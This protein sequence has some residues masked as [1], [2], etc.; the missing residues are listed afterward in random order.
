MALHKGSALGISFDDWLQHPVNPSRSQFIHHR[1]LSIHP[2]I[3]QAI[4]Q[5]IKHSLNQSNPPITHYIYRSID[6]SNQ[7]IA[8]SSKQASNR[9]IDYSIE[10]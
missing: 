10:H 5:S 1:W 7:S 4:D 9:A 2:S 8:L 6:Q 3:H